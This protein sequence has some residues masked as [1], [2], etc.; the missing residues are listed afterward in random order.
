MLRE[1]LTII[2]GDHGLG[3][4]AAAFSQMLKICVDQVVRAGD[5][6][7]GEDLD[8]NERKQIYDWDIQVNQLEQA[9]RKKL[10]VHLSIPANFVDA[11]YCLLL[12]SVVKDVERIGDYAKNLL[13]VSESFSMPSHELAAELRAIREQAEEGL[14]E[15]ADVFEGSASQLALQRVTQGREVARRCDRL[16]GQIGGSSHRVQEGAALALGA[17]Y[18]K[19]INAHVLNVLSSIVMPLHKLDYHDEQ[20]ISTGG[21][22]RR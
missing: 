3:E 10:I 16:L 11:P 19:R 21:A 5:A 13:E 6:C 2:R 9:I 7:F 14:R 1:L 18:Y 22:G 4:V 17:R 8:P 15:L 20:E 12:M